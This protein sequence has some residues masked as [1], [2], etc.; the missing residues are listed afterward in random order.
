MDGN[1]RWAEDQSLPRVQGHERGAES[2]RAITREAA[3]LGVKELTLYAFSTENWNRSTDE[4][5]AL[6]EL[7]KRFLIDERDEIMGNQIRFRAIGELERLP[8]DVLE[9]YRKTRDMSAENTG[10]VLRLALSYGA[11]RELLRAAQGIAR[12]AVTEGIDA[13]LALEEED[14]RRFLYDPSM[15]DP[16]LLIRTAGEMRISNFLLWQVSYSELYVTEVLW[17]EFREP[18]LH[19][20]FSAFAM[21]K[22]RFGGRPEE[23]ESNG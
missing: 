3:R 17:P 22:R 20:A 7:L 6:M 13:A 15:G 18:A 2:V 21:R 5:G 14:L 8:D 11:R 10:M 9:E 1:G 12:L 16:D 23:E 19:A 4:V